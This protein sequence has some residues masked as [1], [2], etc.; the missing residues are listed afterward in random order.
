MVVMTTQ[1][2]PTTPRFGGVF[3]FH[4]QKGSNMSNLIPFN[5]NGSS[6]Q[7]IT[8]ENGE[9]WFIAK[10]VSDV[11]GY[12][13]AFKMTTR[14]DEDEK[15][16]RQFGG[17]GNRGVTVI[18]ESGLYSAILGSTK[19]EAKPFKKWVTSEVLPSI[20]KTGSYSTA[21][22]EKKPS[23]IEPAKEFKALFS[24][25]RLLGLDKNAAAISAN[26]GTV[27]LTGT[28]VLGLLG[29]T[30]LVAENQESLW[31]NVTDL[32]KTV[33]LSGM[34]LNRLF[35]EAGLQERIGDYWQP[36]EKAEG[37]CRL[38]DTGK[39]HNSGTPIQAI[40]WSKESLSK[41]SVQGN[42]TSH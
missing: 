21:Q 28:N 35:S 8:D 38:F 27:K 4:H 3:R 22:I 36:T 29:Q 11:L 30:H 2:T 31:Y 37:L 25:G 14:L 13:D 20:R 40:K 18:N 17:F 33:G 42:E 23:A 10:E 19:P 16:N 6:I 39:S 32:G 9:P 15:Q 34:K 26:Q 1:V 24:V 5:F 12:S 7:V 41:I